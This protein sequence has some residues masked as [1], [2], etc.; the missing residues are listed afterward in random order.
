SSA[1]SK[2]HTFSCSSAPLAKPAASKH[3]EMRGRLRIGCRYQWRGGRPRQAPARTSSCASEPGTPPRDARVPLGTVDRWTQCQTGMT[4]SAGVSSVNY[5]PICVVSLSSPVA[6]GRGKMRR[7][8]CPHPLPR[9]RSLESRGAAD[10]DICLPTRARRCPHPQLPEIT[11]HDPA[12]MDTDR[13]WRCRRGPCARRHGTWTPAAIGG[14]RAEAA[15]K[16]CR[17]GPASANPAETRAP[18]PQQKKRPV[19][20]SLHG[21]LRPTAALPSC[22]LTADGSQGGSWHCRKTGSG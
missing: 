2:G 14:A 21:A 15:G 10:V 12:Q 1:G 8:I 4:H 11:S 17:P 5:H 19:R 3:P 22:P 20:T 18:P 9:D 16:P 7:Q 13:S 6:S